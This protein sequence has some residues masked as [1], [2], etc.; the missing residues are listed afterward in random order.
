MPGATDDVWE[1]LS[2]ARSIR[3]FTDE[4]VDAAVLDRC[5]EAAARYKR[6]VY[7]EIPRDM[8]KIVPGAPHEPSISPPQSDP[9]A[10]AE[11]VQEAGELVRRAKRPK[12]EGPCVR[13]CLPA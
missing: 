6:P 2:T 3:R 12:G 7:I 4:P 1:V 13:E 8:V 5:L 9:D 10:L 11:A